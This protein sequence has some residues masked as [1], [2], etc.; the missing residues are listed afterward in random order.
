MFNEIASIMNSMI[1]LILALS[2][3][4]FAH[5]FVAF[6]QGDRTAKSEGRMTINPVPHIDPVGTLL[7]PLIGSVSGAAIIGWAKPVPVNPN[8][9]RDPKWGYVLVALAG[10]MAN[11]LLCALTLLFFRVVEMQGL[12]NASTDTFMYPLIQLAKPMITINAIL[13]FFNLLPLY[14]LDG[15]TVFAAFLPPK[16]LEWYESYIAPYGMFILIA[17]FLTNSLGWMGR[18]AMGYITFADGIVT[19]IL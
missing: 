15:G 8:Q 1:A 19:S 12:L 4:E 6:L 14:P 7:F 5:A 9:L 2:F 10:P 16:G 17:L 3:H 11:L 18:L 13:A